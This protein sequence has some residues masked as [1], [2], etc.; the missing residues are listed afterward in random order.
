VLSRIGE[1]LESDGGVDGHAL[2]VHTE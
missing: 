1:A 2:V